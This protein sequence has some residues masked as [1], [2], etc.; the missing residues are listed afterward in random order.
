MVAMLNGVKEE[1][2]TRYRLVAVPQCSYS[3]VIQLRNW[4]P[5]AVGGVAWISFDNPGQS[6]R[7]PVFSGTTDLP[8][9][10]SICGQHRHREDAIVWKYRTANKLA[11]VR[12]GLTRDSIQTAIMHFEEKGLTE[13]SFVENRYKELQNS[14]GEEVARSFLTGYTADFAG[15]TILRW[16]EMAD[17]FWEMFARGF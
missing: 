1:T 14:K 3:H 7:I 9:T 13:M 4:L 17:K 15:A 16:E 8:T 5:D 10:F 6:P 12:W 2:V 11:T